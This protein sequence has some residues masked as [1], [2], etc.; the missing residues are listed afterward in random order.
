MRHLRVV[1]LAGWYPAEDDPVAGIFVRRHV[2]AGSR[3]AEAVVVHPAAADV[4]R[5]ALVVDAGEP[6]PTVRARYPRGGSRP[7]A[8]LRLLR[9]VWVGVRAAAGRLGG[10]DVVHVHVL[11][12]TG[13][14]LGLRLA[15]P[16]APVVVTEHW[17]GFLPES[18]T[19]LGWARRALVR[20]Q[21]RT[22]AVVT[23][24]SDHL[25]R[26]MERL[27]FAGRY[28]VVPNVV[29]TDLFRPA[30]PPPPRPLR[31]L[32]VSTLRPLKN[33]RG[34]IE[35]VLAVRATGVDATLD[36]WGWG[37]EGPALVDWVRAR[38]DADAVRIHG[39]GAP[40]RI[41][42]A[43]RGCHALV[44]FSDYE[45]S[46]CVVAEAFA[47]GR[48]VV[49]SRVGGIPEHVDRDRGILVPPGDV[50]ALTSALGDLA[51][52]WRG[53]DF[54]EISRYGYETFSEATVAS[55][56][57]RLYRDVVS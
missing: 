23:T 4:R 44:L 32:H 55:E 9:A 12:G 42:E 33:V 37:A 45:N 35:A 30:P 3:I 22:A 24:P 56:L 6:V 8:H 26:S 11:P 10:V 39:V 34:I 49:A 54:R 15:A 19:R 14:W 20:R 36:V 28:H 40:D 48:P 50:R 53:I 13:A 21:V 5:V 16:S 46:P 29:D 25:R 2:L 31:L 41:A 57:E 51:S 1:H 47:C 7:R 43:Y 52:W 38:A 17:S 27:G 18:R